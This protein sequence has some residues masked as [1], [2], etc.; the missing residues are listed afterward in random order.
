MRL[1]PVAAAGLFAACAYPV[2]RAACAIDS[3]CGPSGFCLGA[4]CRQGTR[5]CPALQPTYS[6]IDRGL[7]QVSC[8]ASG[9]KGINCHS[10]EGAGSASFLDLSGDAYARL[11]NRT[12]VNPLGDLKDLLLVKPG[13]PDASFLVQ[14]LRLT[15]ALDAHLG[16]GMPA[17]APGSICASSV[18]AIA[19]WIR[20]GAGRN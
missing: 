12:A 20:E 6:S 16:S 14:K 3:D 5:A 15:T 17:D 7:F 4:T 11:V 13:D 1:A 9:S 19:Q 8:G 10:P 18:D 2:D